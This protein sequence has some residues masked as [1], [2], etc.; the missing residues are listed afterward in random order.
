MHRDPRPSGV[1]LVAL[2]LWL[3]ACVGPKP[4]VIGSVFVRPPDPETAFDRAAHDAAVRGLRAA[5]FI[6]PPESADADAE[7]EVSWVVEPNDRRRGRVRVRLH[8]A[9]G[10]VLREQ[11]SVAAPTGFW[12]TAR[13]ADETRGLIEPWGRAPWPSPPTAIPVP[14]DN[15]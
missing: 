5:G 12:T 6:V 1:L 11:L 15:P 3:T 4:M 9:P 13:I 10:R 8:D 2:T 14:P 7:L